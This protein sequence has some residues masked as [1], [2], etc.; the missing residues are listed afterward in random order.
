[1]RRWVLIVAAAVVLAALAAFRELAERWQQP[2][3]VPPQ[4]M[5]VTVAAGESLRGV[6]NRLYAQGVLSHP[7]LLVLYGRWTGLDQQIKHGEFQLP[8]GATAE[9]LLR[10]LHSGKVVQYQVTLP[11]GITLARALAI[12]AQQA[13]LVHVLEG[14]DD[15][16]ISQLVEPRRAGVRVAIAAQ[17]GPVVLRDDQQH[18]RPRGQRRGMRQRAQPR[19]RRPKDLCPQVVWRKHRIKPLMNANER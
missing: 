5:I 11:E 9:S 12:L 14:P 18:V 7:K 10:M 17:L 8:P 3:A 1:M 6:V 13:G 4:G 16:R 15:A 19:Q 2:L